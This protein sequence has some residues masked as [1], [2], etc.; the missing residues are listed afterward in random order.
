MGK[1]LIGGASDF[2]LLGIKFSV[3]LSNMIELNYLPAINN[4]EKLLNLWSH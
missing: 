3:D 1:D 4:L 2:T